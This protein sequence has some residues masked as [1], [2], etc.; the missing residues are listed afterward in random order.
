MHLIIIIGPPAVGKMTVGRALSQLTGIPLFHNHM[1]LELVN[2]FF[3]FGTPPFWRLDKLIR[4]GIFKEVAQSD[5]PG[6][7]FT[8]VCD[9]DDPRDEAYLDEICDIFRAEGANICLAELSAALEER[10]IRN[11]G[12][13]RIAAKPSKQDVQASEKRLLHHE[14]AHRMN[15]LPG[16]YEGKE[17]FKVD[18]THLSPEDAARRIQVH[19]G[20]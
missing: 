7:I 18:N 8:L 4:F 6:L 2:Q 17:L 16:D 14:Q 12:A 9:F 11:R 1:S 20:L 15:S 10:L 13:D 3:D 19:F 5:L